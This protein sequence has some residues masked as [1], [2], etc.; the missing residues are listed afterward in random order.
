VQHWGE[1]FAPEY[2]PDPSLVTPPAN[3][4]PAQPNDAYTG[5]YANDFYGTFE[6]T[7]GPAGLSLVEGPAKVTFPLTHFD[8]NTF[9]EFPVAG[10]PHK[11]LAIEFT[12]GPDGKA[13]AI[14]L[15]GAD[16]GGLE[17]LTRA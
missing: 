8:G 16:G 6:V 5:S 13:S 11:P 3:P 7:D 4:T 9:L 12:M 10:E 14:S 17:T 1:H 2:I 15:G